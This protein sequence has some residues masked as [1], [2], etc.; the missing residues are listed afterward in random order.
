MSEQINTVQMTAEE[1]ESYK[2]FQAQKAKKAQEA[3]RKQDR[4]TY[5]KL[6]DETIDGVFPSVLDISKSLTLAK[7]GIRESFQKAL[8]LKAQV[9]EVNPDRRSNMFTHSD[10][11]HRIVLGEHELD[12]W[13]DTVN[14]GVAKVK[15]YIGSLA[16]DPESKMLVNAVMKLLSKDKEGNLRASRVMQL[17]QMASDSDNETFIDG[18]RII[19]EAHRP[20][21]SK[22]YI[23]AECKDENGAWTTI[24]LGITEA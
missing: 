6:V 21:V 4:E 1:L 9:F 16:K 2:E 10:G 5:K 18:V 11:K 19:K 15:E 3:Q 13:D 23:R 7:K 12:A 24:P 8:E 20:T 14:E 17:E 22:T